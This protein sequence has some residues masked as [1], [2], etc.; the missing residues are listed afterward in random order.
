MLNID[1]D[2][3]E[4]LLKK[5]M[6]QIDLLIQQDDLTNL[7]KCLYNYTSGLNTICVIS[8]RYIQ[9][10]SPP[11][12]KTNETS[13]KLIK[14][15]FK[16]KPELIDILSDFNNNYFFFE[17]PLSK[18][19]LIGNIE[20][21]EYFV[22][23]NPNI[24]IFIY[25]VAFLNA[26]TSGNLDIVKYLLLIKPEIRTSFKNGDPIK[27]ACQSGNLELVKYIIKLHPTFDI[28]KKDL[29]IYICIYGSVD[30][31]TY[32]I[33]STSNIDITTLII[34]NKIIL[35]DLCKQGKLEVLKYLVDKCSPYF[36]YNKSLFGCA[37][38]SGN[39]KLVEYL[40]DLY[41]NY[42]DLIRCNHQEHYKLFIKSC[43]SNNIELV[44]F[45]LSIS[46]WTILLKPADKFYISNICSKGN[47]PL[48]KLYLQYIGDFN[49]SYENELCFTN[50]C[51][52]GNINL[53]QYLLKIK[54]DINIHINNEKPFISACI[55]G[56]LDL[57]KYLL[58]IK[59][60]IDI[61]IDDYNCLSKAYFHKQ[62]NIIRFLINR[63][64]C[65]IVKYKS[66]YHGFD[67]YLNLL[68]KKIQHWWK[69]ILY[70]PHK[71][72][73]KKFIEKQIEWAW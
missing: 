1:I 31:I 44:Q 63:N 28:S 72:I 69:S 62:T 8:N 46:T 53:V 37:C 49:L 34:K 54:P 68:I 36:T 25:N 47:L 73:G 9:I 45:I 3:E 15:L 22:T 56:N 10:Q 33:E 30:I 12:Q 18:A 50:A 51:L 29:F 21:V 67:L 60:I 66:R 38:Y 42:Y 27:Y 35:N 19:C 20:L 43:I 52:S 65:L 55:S 24:N 71:E 23:I 61:G 59:P 32:L 16:L 5:N 7:K 40:L 57:V 4:E 39:L 17:D 14:Y 48:V 26:C 2:Y 13:I 11:N 70:N 6:K 58:R 64:P 41:P